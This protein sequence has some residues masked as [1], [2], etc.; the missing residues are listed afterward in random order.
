MRISFI[1]DSAHVWV[2]IM[3]QVPVQV[4]PPF[5]PPPKRVHG[6]LQVRGASAFFGVEMRLFI[7]TEARCPHCASKSLC[8]SYSIFMRSLGRPS[9]VPNVL[10]DHLLLAFFGG[11]FTPGVGFKGAGEKGATPGMCPG[12]TDI[13]HFPLSWILVLTWVPQGMHG[14]T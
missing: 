6:L 1:Q 2:F 3:R 10:C 11:T 14:L 13:S 8:H 5:T 12:C 9:A 4:A 7:A